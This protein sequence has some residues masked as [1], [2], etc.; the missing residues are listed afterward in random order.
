MTFL[1][2]KF[3]FMQED[4]KMNNAI[5]FSKNKEELLSKIV[6][7]IND[8]TIKEE[9]RGYF[10]EWRKWFNENG[11]SIELKDLSSTNNF[12]RAY[13]HSGIFGIQIWELNDEGLVVWKKNIYVSGPDVLDDTDTIVINKIC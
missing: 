2:M 1:V 7:I 13:Y 10:K 11:K 12:Y 8:D 6:M 9:I 3:A 4:T 5:L